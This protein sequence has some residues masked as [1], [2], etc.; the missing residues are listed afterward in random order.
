MAAIL[1]HIPD[2]TAFDPAAIEAMAKAFDE[3]C[4]ALQIFDGDEANRRVIAT[5]VVD[6]ARNGVIE[7]DALR[8]RILAEAHLSL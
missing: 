5:R 3:A 4:A 2:Q 6:L 8:D 1:R 7:A